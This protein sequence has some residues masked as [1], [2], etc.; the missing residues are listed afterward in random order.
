VN[1]PPSGIYGQHGSHE[2]GP[3]QADAFA[4][5]TAVLCD[6]PEA[7]EL[8]WTGGSPV[9]QEMLAIRVAAIAIS[10]ASIVATENEMELVEWLQLCAT[11]LQEKNLE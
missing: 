2:L 5:V 1:W 9:W 11:K 6:D 10:Q 7:V 4:F 8:V 3:T